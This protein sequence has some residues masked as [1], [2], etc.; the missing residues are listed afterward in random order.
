MEASQ[1]PTIAVFDSGVGGMTILASLV[2]KIPDASYVYFGDTANAPYGSRSTD[3][4]FALSSGA[5]EKLLTYKPAV[6]VIACNTATSTSI[7]KIREKFPTMIVVGVEPAVKPAVIVS[8]KKKIIVVATTATL[9]SDSYQA[10]KNTWAAGVEVLDLP[11]PEWV[12]MVEESKIDDDILSADAAD[13]VA[14]GADTLVLACTHFPFLK[15]KLQQLMPDMM[16]IDSAEPV[17]QRVWRGLGEPKST[18]KQPAAITWL[19]SDPQGPNEMAHQIL[20]TKALE[21]G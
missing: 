17:A 8:N 16:I 9:Q 7:V 14:S 19:F 10:L 4:I 18:V 12:R 15:R 21:I 3:E 5:I 13:I 20:W 6:I 11:K 1:R 2:K